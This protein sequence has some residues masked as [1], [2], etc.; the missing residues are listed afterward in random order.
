MEHWL[1]QRL[2]GVAEE[3]LQLE[4]SLFRAQHTLWRKAP[5]RRE[6]Y[7][8]FVARYQGEG[9]L[10]LFQEYSVLARL[11]IVV[12]EQWIEACR[13]FLQRLTGD[14]DAITQQFHDGS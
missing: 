10:S 13:E 4:F 1:L 6:L 9:L 11:L 7:Q 8:A 3:V 12:M 5:E 14:L 2:A